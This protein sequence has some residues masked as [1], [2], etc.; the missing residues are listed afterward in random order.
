MQSYE[1]EESAK[2]KVDRA[3]LYKAT[4]HGRCS[5]HDLRT[6]RIRPIFATN[7]P[8]SALPLIIGLYIYIYGFCSVVRRIIGRHYHPHCYHYYEEIGS[9]APKML[10]PRRT[11]STIPPPTTPYHT[12]FSQSLWP[13]TPC[14]ILRQASRNHLTSKRDASSHIYILG[15]ISGLITAS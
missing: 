8:I 13:Y 6:K 5:S 10:D 9:I 4:E 12:P 2:S 11:S 1:T 14:N 7:S 15:I 3:P